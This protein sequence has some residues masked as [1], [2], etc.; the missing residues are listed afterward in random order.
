MDSVMAPPR[1]YALPVTRPWDELKNRTNFL[2]RDLVLELCVRASLRVPG[3]IMEFG[4]A[5]GASTRVIRRTLHKYGSP[6]F[7]PFGRK[8]IF[9]LDS[10]EGLREKFENADIGTFAGAV[11]KMAG[12]RFVKGYFE[13]TCTDALRAEVGQVALAHLDADLH[14][15]TLFA[16][17][18]L[19]PLLGTGSMLL[20]DEFT[21][22]DL[23]EARAFETWRQESGLEVIRLAEF[24]RDPSGFGTQIDRRALFQV[25]GTGTLAPRPDRTRLA[26]KIAYYLGRLGFEEQKNRIEAYL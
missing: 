16:L 26:W 10:F 19:V 4:V 20:F 2:S 17:R 24:D 25:V 5:S 18:W 1:G 11:P 21:G 7:V 13:D 23:A 6:W 3:H 22:G 15:S 8:K 12:V 14:S 9:A